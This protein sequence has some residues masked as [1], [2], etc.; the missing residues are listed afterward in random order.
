MKNRP[1]HHQWIPAFAGMT[2]GLS[3]PRK[4]ESSPF[5]MHSGEPRDHGIFAQDDS[6]R[7]S[8]TFKAPVLHSRF[9]CVELHAWAV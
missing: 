8:H 4:R 9:C 7:F 2:P 6:A 1:R 5:F 3:F